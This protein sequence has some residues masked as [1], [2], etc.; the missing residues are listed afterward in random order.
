MKVELYGEPG[1]FANVDIDALL[2]ALQ[3]FDDLDHLLKE[4]EF[5]W[6]RRGGT[7]TVSLAGPAAGHLPRRLVQAFGVKRFGPDGA[8]E[9]TAADVPVWQDVLSRVRVR[10]G[11][12]AAVLQQIE[13]GEMTINR[14]MR[15]AARARARTRKGA[16]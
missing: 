6:Q 3:D 16:P 2:P 4:P 14:Q 13:R 10:A 9:A 15:R 8:Y 12:S 1:L 7:L 11:V 5:R